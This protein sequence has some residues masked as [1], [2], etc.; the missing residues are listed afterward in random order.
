LLQ[1]ID[2]PHSPDYLKAAL[3]VLV[4]R[5]LVPAQDLDR[6]ASLPEQFLYPVPLDPTQSPAVQT[7][8][9]FCCS[10]LHARIELPLADLIAF[11]AFTLQYDRS[12]L[13]TADKLADRIERQIA[14]TVSLSSAIVALAEIVGSER[15]EPVETDASESR[16]TRSGQ[17]TLITMHKAKGLDWDYVFLPFLHEATIPGNLR[18][19]PQSKFLGEFTLAEVARA[20]IRILLRDRELDRRPDRGSDRSGDRR[21]AIPDPQTSWHIAEQLKIAEEFRLLYVAMTRAKRLLWMSAAKL[22]PF[23]WNKPENLDERAP[24][25][26]LT[27][28]LSH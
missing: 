21:T 11:V 25:P 26:V 18:V 17:L 23:T 10:L 3:T 20:Q 1:F 7:A 12:E 14:E 9:R 6:L 5:Q 28:L 2:R 24:C 16:Y 15:F 27:A 13:A 4:D 8:R 22:A 19:P